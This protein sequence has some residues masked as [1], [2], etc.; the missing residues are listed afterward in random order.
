MHHVSR[1]SRLLAVGLTAICALAFESPA[2]ADTGG[3]GTPGDTATP[4]PTALAPA[5]PS[6]PPGRVQILKNGTA[7]APAGAPPAIQAAVAAGNA[8]HTESYCW[9]GGHQ[10]FT[11][12][13]KDCS[14]AV[15]RLLHD[16]GMLSSPMTS[17]A[18]ATGWGVP[19]KGQWLT[20]YANPSHTYM[21]VGGARFDTSA[22]GERLNQGSGPRWRRA[23][24]K[25]TGYTARYFPGY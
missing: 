24:R 12:S 25:A 11:S 16:A 23:K 3:T 19:G 14:G 22:V 13:C 2:F 17:G 21:V 8:I 1:K 4:A 18:L 9:G 5:A 10:S 15:S 6:G 20:V 7:V